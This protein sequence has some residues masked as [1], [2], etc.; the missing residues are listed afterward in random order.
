MHLVQYGCC[1]FS[2]LVLYG[3]STIEPRHVSHRSYSVRVM[4]QLFH[5]YDTG[6]EYLHRFLVAGTLD[7]LS[8]EWSDFL[9]QTHVPLSARPTLVSNF[10]LL[11]SHRNRSQK[12]GF[13]SCRG[14]E[15]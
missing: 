3:Y 10:V 11:C 1:A 15:M 7:S 13:S 12:A 6:T 9:G 8:I 4:L 14:A 5:P 2:L